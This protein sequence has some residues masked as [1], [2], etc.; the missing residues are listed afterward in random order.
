LKIKVK[1]NYDR[2]DKFIYQYL[3]TVPISLIQRL[4]RKHKIKI[5][6]KKS[7]YNSVIKTG[8]IIYIYYEFEYTSD[9]KKYLK[10]SKETKLKFKQRIVYENNDF[11]IINKLKGYSVQRGSKIKNSLKDFYESLLNSNLYIVHRLDKDTTGLMIFAK[12]KLS[13]SKLSKMFQ[14]NLINKYY[15]A[16]TVKNFQ[17]KNGFLI[18]IN[19]DNKVLKLIY[20][21]I[22]LPK[23]KNCYLIKLLTGKKHQIRLQFFLNKNPIIGDKKFNQKSNNDL[24]LSSVFLNFNYENKLYKFRLNI[25]QI[26]L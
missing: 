17:K 6:N 25:N 18:N 23:L 14:K 1:N 8:D 26:F 11:I 19:K 10:L 21:E 16:L 4:I 9:P 13:A 5:N 24:M 22:N 15:I 2:L 3:E 12:N 7:K 20:R